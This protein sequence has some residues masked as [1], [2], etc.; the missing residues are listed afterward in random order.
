MTQ[1]VN[2]IASSSRLQT[3]LN[4]TLTATVGEPVQTLATLCQNHLTTITNEAM[5]INSAL[6]VNQAR[7]ANHLLNNALTAVV[8]PLTALQ[9]ELGRSHGVVE[10]QDHDAAALIGKTALSAGEGSQI[11][12]IIGEFLGYAGGGSYS[13]VPGMSPKVRGV[14]RYKCPHS[15]CNYEEGR[16]RVE[17]P[18]PKCPKHGCTMDRADAK[19]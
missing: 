3:H 10:S 6:S 13:P 4:R 19:T 2:L 18:V 1:I 17:D 15:G 14:E 5:S 8:A 9:E 11:G 16:R 12:G 7:Q